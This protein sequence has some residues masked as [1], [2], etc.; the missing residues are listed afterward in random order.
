MYAARW[1]KAAVLY[2]CIGV[3]FGLYMEYT[4]V[5]PNPLSGFHAHVNLLGWASMAL[6]GCIYRAFPALENSKLAPAQFWLYQ[7]FTPIMML[8]LYLILGMNMPQIGGPSMLVAAHGVVLSILLFAVA[9]WGTLKGA[10]AS[11]SEE[12]T[13]AS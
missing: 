11:A 1:V 3:G 5:H 10:N 13:K 2:F 9:V 6:I 7:I 8:G 4:G 12:V